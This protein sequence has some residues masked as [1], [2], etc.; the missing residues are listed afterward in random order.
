MG[1][2]KRKDVLRIFSLYRSILHT[3]S[4]VG[5]RTPTKSSVQGCITGSMMERELWDIYRLAKI[6]TE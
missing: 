1:L 5:C 2:F 6:G 3:S 4:L